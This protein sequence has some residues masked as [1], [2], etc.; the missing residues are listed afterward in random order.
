MTID[1]ECARD[2]AKMD[3]IGDYSQD[4]PLAHKFINL[5]INLLLIN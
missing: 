4:D 2:L 3:F 5:L 1:M